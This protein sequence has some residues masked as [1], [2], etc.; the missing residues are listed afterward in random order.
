MIP[1]FEDEL[2]AIIAEQERQHLVGLD[3]PAPDLTALLGK[4][5][6]VRVIQIASF[7]CE[8]P[9]EGTLQHA[10]ELAIAAHGYDDYLTFIIAGNGK[11]V[12]AYLAVESA[13]VT[14]QLLHS[15]YPGVLLD[16]R[17]AIGLPRELASHFRCAGMI[18]GVPAS[19]QVSGQQRSPRGE[20]GRFHFERVIRGM[21]ST[22]WG[23]IMQA[24]PRSGD[25]LDHREKLLVRMSH[26]SS[27]A[28]QQVQ[29]T[30]QE[31]VSRRNRETQS[32][33]E[34][35]GGEIVDR[36]AE[37]GVELLERALKRSERAVALGW[38]QAAVYFGAESEDHATRL[39][40]LLT[41]ILSGP[42]S[43]P[44]PIRVHQCST[45][46]Y[47]KAEE[48]HTYLTSEELAIEI[49]LPQEEVPGLAITD[50]A[51]FDVCGQAVT[52]GIAV[53]DVLWDDR[54]TNEQYRV[55][56]DDLT[57]HG[58]VFG[59]TGSGKTTTLL[60]LLSN[61]SEPPR[62]VPF[63]VI[64]PAKT[65]YR[66]LLGRIHD[67]KP[68]GEVPHL[69]VYT[70]G[71]DTVAPFRLNP[72]E[73]DLPTSYTPVPVLSHIDFLKAVFNA[74]FILYAP[75]PYVLDMALHEI[76]EDKGWNLA[77]GINVRLPADEWSRR[78]SYPIFPT[79]T[80]LYQKVESV[81]RRLGYETKIEQDVVAGL[82]ARVGSLR[83]GAKGL[84]LDT[85]RGIPMDDLLSRPVVLEL[86]HI[87]N[88]DEKTFIMGLLLARLYGFRRLQAAEGHL[89][90]RLEHLL[91]VE[92]AHRLLKNTSTTVE[93]EA[94]NLRAQAIETFINMLSE[95]R[96]Y[97]QGVLVAEQIPTKL[98][99]DV[100][101][102]TNLKIIHR[103]LAQDDRELVGKTMNMSEGQMRRLAWLNRG[104]AAVFAEGD[105]HPLLV[106]V[107]NFRTRHRQGPPSDAVLGSF[108]ERFLNLQPYLRVPSLDSYGVRLGRLQRPDPI[109]YQE[110]TQQLA[111]E[112]SIGLWARLLLQIVFA[113]EAVSATLALL[114]QTIATTARQLT[115]GQHAAAL[116]ILLVL[117]ADEALQSRGSERGWPFAAVDALRD[118]LTS[119]LLRLARTGDLQAAA[120][121]LDRFARAYDG[122]LRD[123]LGPHP[124]CR[125]CRA[126]CLY[127][128]EI[129]RL[130][131]PSDYYAVRGML[132][133]RGRSREE[134]HTGLA[135]MLRA[136]VKHW[137]GAEGTEAENM[138]YCLALT[139]APAIGM[140]PYE[141]EDFGQEMA[142]NLLV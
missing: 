13:E 134:R 79:L 129:C 4:R 33:S 87:G 76:Y 54:Q 40:A 43:Q 115:P 102:N 58:V 3:A 138:A 60:G 27:R 46:A 1:A 52:N 118:S 6:F 20:P 74:A 84:M 41:S 139:V 88:D 141:Q 95:V 101:K 5:E 119:G 39:G 98:T 77:T 36:R 103:L 49:L 29:R 61:L 106:K 111:R 50:Y 97:G 18:S 120:T 19:P 34:V 96:H 23:Y 15:A 110:V 51:P 65:E 99:P 81:T 11:R 30:I 38:W 127:Q 59:V 112:G 121:E 140:D 8:H 14:R 73:F 48:F 9:D 28:R 107:K 82:K 90:S 70:L 109:I 123:V 32:A 78:E 7:W 104:Q 68:D 10:V 22:R 113:R 21:R 2:T 125:S 64:E 26:L 72:F 91:I 16:D 132:T 131:V 75:M 133:D 108:A 67:G 42:D 44:S 142:A 71:N 80:D 126:P 37:Y 66:S 12:S 117:G 114:R 17:S 69:Q 92:E 122:Q 55:A 63:L 136:T 56:V 62:S 124:G 85:P 128:L 45:G 93:T 24:F 25:V 83:L 53:G 47:T 86:E 89:A 57:R 116:Q 130:I 35:H 94:A 31:S 105:D 137:L 135:A 100:I